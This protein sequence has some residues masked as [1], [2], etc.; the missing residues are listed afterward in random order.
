[1]S[2]KPQIAF[3][4]A[5]HLC[6][7]L[8]K[9]LINHPSQA[10]PAHSI[11]AINRNQSKRSIFESLGVKTSA[12]P[13]DAYQSSCIFLGVRP[14]QLSELLGNHAKDFTQARLIISL[15][16]GARLEFFQQFFPKNQVVVRLM[17]NLASEVHS[18]V[19]ALYAEHLSEEN[20]SFI[21]T[22]SKAW[23]KSIWLTN[24]QDM[25]KYTAVFGSG[26]AYIF[27]LMENCGDFLGDSLES[28]VKLGLV[29]SLLI[30]AGSYAVEQD[31]SFPELI[32]SIAVRGGTTEKAL[33]VMDSHGYSSSFIKGLESAR[34]RA[35]EIGDWLAAR[36]EK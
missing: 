31:S 36:L 1:M 5:G 16:A 4:G 27:K 10:F 23:G 3:V 11:L 14:S 20:K 32:S 26:M 21:D 28:E 7:A 13:E 17:P 22:I 18:G 15:A 24:E 12:Q 2:S 6:L 29:Q 33:E 9:G 30:G 25:D 19:T 34:L 8:I 35:E